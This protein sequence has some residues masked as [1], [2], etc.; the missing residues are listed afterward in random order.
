M[1]LSRRYEVYYLQKVSGATTGLPP[2]FDIE[3]I[4]TDGCVVMGLYVQNASDTRT[5]ADAG[6][7]VTQGRFVTG[8]NEDLLP[9]HVLRRASDSMFIKLTNDAMVASPHAIS[10]FKLFNVTVINRKDVAHDTNS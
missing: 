8:T 7:V 9:D 3:N 4:F 5:V 10:Q 1:D 2:P 6:R